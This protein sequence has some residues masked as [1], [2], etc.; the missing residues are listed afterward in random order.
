[1]RFVRTVLVTIIWLAMLN[2]AMAL[3][4]CVTP[5][6]AMALK[7]ALVR[8]QLMVA[9]VACH[10][11]TLYDLFLKAHDAELKDSDDTLQAF[12]RQHGGNYDTYRADA[13]RLAVMGQSWNA[14]AFCT[15]SGQLFSMALHSSA[16]LIG[17]I[18]SAPALPGLAIA[19]KREDSIP[20][21]TAMNL[22]AAN[23]P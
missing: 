18:A 12:F 8:Q 15:A 5:S 16:S 1:M 23:W 3:G 17:M 7:T 9:G 6:Q 20:P 11:T 2:P 19:C 21:T 22:A 14:G 13:T 10:E 4:E